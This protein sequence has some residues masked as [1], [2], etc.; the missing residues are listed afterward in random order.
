MSTEEDYEA[1]VALAKQVRHEIEALE[2]DAKVRNNYNEFRR[3]FKVAGVTLTAAQASQLWKESAAE[4]EEVENSDEDDAADEDPVE[5][6][7]RW[8]GCFTPRRRARAGTF[9]GRAPTGFLHPYS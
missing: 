1:W 9:I 7:C 6:A 2:G 4:Y 3:R 8:V 5:E